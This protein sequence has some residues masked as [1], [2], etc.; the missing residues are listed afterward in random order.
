MAEYLIQKDTLTAIADAIRSKT[1]KDDTILVS[2]LATEISNININGWNDV[3]L[4]EDIFKYT[5]YRIDDK[6]KEIIIY[7]ILYTPL[8][9]ITK[10]FNITVPDKIGE[11]QIVLNSKGAE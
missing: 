2:D 11:Y 1:N 10:N 6:K 9:Q 5:T 4:N 3:P 7:G 8:Y